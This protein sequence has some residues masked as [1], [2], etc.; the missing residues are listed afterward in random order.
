MIKL[1]YIWHDCFLFQNDNIAIVFDYWR[2]PHSKKGEIPDFINDLD[3]DKPFYVLVSHHHKDHYVKEIFDWNRLFP[4]IK[5]ILSKDTAKFARHIIKENS[6]YVGTRPD[7]KNIIVLNSGEMYND[8]YLRVR[9]FDS[10]DIGNSYVIEIGDAN[11][12]HAG[13]LN[14]WIWKDESSEEEVEAELKR[15]TGILNMIA[16]KYQT[17]DIAMFPVD[18]R[19]GT[20]YFTGAKLFVRKFDV[21]HFFP[22]HFGLGEKEENI[23][24][25]RDA[26]RVE[27][28]V[29]PDRGEYICLQSPYSCFYKS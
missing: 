12:F 19:I 1:Q 21:K 16:E 10:T 20:D 6:I 25:R 7:P 11:I 15:F 9:A 3:K 24:Y 26:A 8:D 5:F 2:D 28:Y 29:N 27:N 22:M 13:D 14:A 18:S 23:K 17:F 4:D